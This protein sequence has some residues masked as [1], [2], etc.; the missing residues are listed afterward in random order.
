MR[1]VD[2][3]TEH[4]LESS[5]SAVDATD[6]GTAI[7]LVLAVVGSI[8]VLLGAYLTVRSGDV[9]PQ[10]VVGI[11]TVTVWIALSGELHGEA[12]TEHDD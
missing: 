3:V 11:G 9:H 7:G 5:G 1:G 10:L 4:R 6:S 2:H 8:A 12:T